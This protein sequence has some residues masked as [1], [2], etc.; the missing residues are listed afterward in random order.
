MDFESELEAAIERGQHRS[1]QQQESMRQARL[2]AEEL[3]QRHTQFRLSLSEHIEDCLK[4]LET[5]FPGFEYETLYGDRGWGG[6]ISRTD[7]DRGPDGRAGSFFSRLELT[8]RPF[9]EFHV[10]NI[11]GKGTIRD[12]EIFNWNHY[13]D[14]ADVDQDAYEKMLDRWALQYAEMF[15]AR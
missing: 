2:S 14:I 12:K 8:V 7:L 6:A 3:R 15:A 11:A 4:K 1:E 9:N 5:H 13:E 10:V